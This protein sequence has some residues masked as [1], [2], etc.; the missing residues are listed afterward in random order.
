[1]QKELLKELIEIAIF[2]WSYHWEEIGSPGDKTT[3]LF[4]NSKWGQPLDV[5]AKDLPAGCEITTDRRRMRE[6]AAVVFHI[7][8][9]PS[10][11]RIRKFPGQLWVVWSQE[12]E[13]YYRRLRD[14]N[15][16]RQF[17]L[18][19]TYHR[20]ADIPFP[21]YGPGFLH[22]LKTPP[23]P[24]TK[25]K[26]AALFVSGFVGRSGRFKYAT[27]LMRYLD[28]HSYGK[29]LRNRRLEQDR[30]RATKLETIADYKFTLAFE[31]AIAEDYVTEKFFD[32]LSVGSVPVYLGAPNVDEFA[33]ADRC[34]INTSDFHSPK[35][36]AEYLL[37]LNEDDAA[38]EQYLAWRHRPL[39]PSFLNLLDER[40][41]HPFVRLCQKVQE[42]RARSHVSYD[43]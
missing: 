4:F 25:D 11:N 16:L 26:L 22:S 3:I 42:L 35:A 9:L 40:R 12:C 27:E 7:P 38:Y 29:R 30:G 6:A 2:K 24:K 19:M 15:F 8:S 33:P 28:V 14:P 13:A 31:N 20:Q 17:D 5:P 21:Y 39:R 23:K 1:M 10:L 41:T 18:T 36:L 32:P 43:P 37:L 34:F